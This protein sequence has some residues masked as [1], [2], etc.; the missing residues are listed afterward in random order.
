MS[1]LNQYAQVEFRAHSFH[2]NAI[3]VVYGYGN[4]CNCIA[5]NLMS[6]ALWVFAC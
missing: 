3:A 6:T 4:Q 2:W 1:R 5:M